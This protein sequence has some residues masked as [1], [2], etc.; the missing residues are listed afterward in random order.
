MNVVALNINEKLPEAI[1]RNDST[2]EA[3]IITMRI[4]GHANPMSEV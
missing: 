2:D 3:E 1:S 4:N